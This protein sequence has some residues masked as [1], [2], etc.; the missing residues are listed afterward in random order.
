MALPGLSGLLLAAMH[1]R[2]RA[3]HPE[4]CGVALLAVGPY[5]ADFVDLSVWFELLDAK[6][7]G[8]G[9]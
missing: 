8:G 4:V 3:C 9:A 1:A 7:A 2:T 5:A 6:L